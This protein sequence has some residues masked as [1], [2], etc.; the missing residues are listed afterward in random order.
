MA[1]NATPNHLLSLRA[2]RIASV[3]TAFYRGLV[4]ES[5]VVGS[6]KWH[7]V[8]SKTTNIFCP[9]LPGSAAGIRQMNPCC[10]VFK[11]KWVSAPSGSISSITASRSEEHTS[12]LQSPY[13]LVCR[14]L[15]EK[16]K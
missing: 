5:S 12:E 15:L 9:G 13:D 14:L 7:L 3:E 2:S 8:K 16:K 4:R 10:P 1:T 6:K 11:W